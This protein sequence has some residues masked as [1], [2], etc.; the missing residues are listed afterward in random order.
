M[1]KLFSDHAPYMH[2]VEL[3]YNDTLGPD[4]FG[5][6]LSQYRGFSLSEVKKCIGDT[7]WH[8]NFCFYHGGFFYCVLNSEGLLRE[9]PLYTIKI[10]TDL[11][12]MSLYNNLHTF[13]L[14]ETGGGNL[15]VPSNF[16]ATIFSLLSKGTLLDFSNSWCWFCVVS[17]VV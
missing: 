16:V 15:R 5:H 2:T 10:V 4:I 1:L 12:H 9:V 17:Y 8:Q 6:F 13:A 7:C 14:C 11:Y 3:F